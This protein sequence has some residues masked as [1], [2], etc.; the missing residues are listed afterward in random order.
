MS[1]RIIT[2]A[3]GTAHVTSADD[4]SINMAIFGNGSGVFKNGEKLDASIIDNNTVRLSDGDVIMQGRVG[5]INPNTTEDVT[6]STGEVGMNRTDLICVRYQLDTNTGYESMDLVVIEGTAT[7][8]AA[9]DPEYNQGDIRTGATL[10]DFPLYRVKIN[11]INID[12]LEKLFEEVSASADR[13]GGKISADDIEGMDGK[14]EQNK[15]SINDLTESLTTLRLPDYNNAI[16]LS[17]ILDAQGKT[18]VAPKDGIIQLHFEKVKNDTVSVVQYT[19]DD[20]EVMYNYVH[21]NV[22]TYSICKC[23]V[24]KDD[25]VTCGYCSNVLMDNKLIFIPFKS[26]KTK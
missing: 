15:T 6:I 11:G 18:W 13:L 5:R 2:G 25:V 24:S 4:G 10:V 23:V 1:L 21:S 12:G 20:V 14:I 3:T 26:Y 17:G 7:E 16:T 19:I 22:I 9:T 8:G